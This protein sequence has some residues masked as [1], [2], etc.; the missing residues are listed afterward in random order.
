[1]EK[2][3]QVLESLKTVDRIV[4]VFETCVDFGLTLTDAKKVAQKWQIQR[5]MGA[6]F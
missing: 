3:T 1:M 4:D 6:G 2:I 5:T